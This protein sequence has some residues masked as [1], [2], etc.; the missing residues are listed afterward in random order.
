VVTNISWPLYLPLPGR[1]QAEPG[2]ATESGCDQRG[3][4][5]DPARAAH[6]P[7]GP[8]PGMLASAGGAVGHGSA[9]LALLAVAL[10]VVV[11]AGAAKTER[12]RTRR[13]RRRA[14]SLPGRATVVGVV[15]LGLL[16]G[17]TSTGGVI[18]RAVLTGLVAIGHAVAG[19]LP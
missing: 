1:G 10:L 3:S 5:V 6:R 16:L 11:V 9:A 17:A 4:G 8:N 13:T 7:L 15:L 14:H 18:A 2:R 19:M 12:R